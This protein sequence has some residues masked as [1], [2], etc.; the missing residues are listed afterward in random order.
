MEDGNALVDWLLGL[1][2][3]SDGEQGDASDGAE[4]GDGE[5]EDDEEIRNKL[6]QLGYLE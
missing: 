4:T 2:G 5:A 6:E 3:W 1:V